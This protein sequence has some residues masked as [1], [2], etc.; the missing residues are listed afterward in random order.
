MDLP[1]KPFKYINRGIPNQG[2]IWRPVLPIKIIYNHTS[3]KSF[4]AYLDSGSDYCLFHASVGAAIGIKIMQGSEGDLG[5][6]IS[7]TRSKVWYHYI[8]LVIGQDIIQTKAGFSWDLDCNL[9]GQIG[10]FDHYKIEFNPISHPPRV[11][12]SLIPSN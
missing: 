9:L 5:G 8:K 4:D 11:S 1:Y 6:V 3:S 2:I 10:F 12:F 7:K